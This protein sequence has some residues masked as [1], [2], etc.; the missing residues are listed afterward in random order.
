MPE[1][2]YEPY[3]VI[4]YNPHGPIDPAWDRAMELALCRTQARGDL[5]VF[6][7]NSASLI[8][9]FSSKAKI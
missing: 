4:P 5:K 7:S 6:G 2:V 9:E 1:I 8:N 3:K